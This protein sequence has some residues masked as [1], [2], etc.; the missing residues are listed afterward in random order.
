MVSRV[1]CV[2]TP[3]DTIPPTPILSLPS[4]LFFFPFF[5]PPLFPPPSP[6]T[7]PSSPRLK[8]SSAKGDSNHAGGP[9]ESIVL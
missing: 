1:V 5:S 6:L 4:S 7:H 2:S 9:G 8:K 3:D